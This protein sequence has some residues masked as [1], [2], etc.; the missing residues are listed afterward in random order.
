MTGTEILALFEDIID[1]SWDEDSAFLLMDSAKVAVEED[2]PWEFLKTEDSSKSRAVGDTF[3]STKAL[4]TNFGRDYKM[5]V[6][7]SLIEYFPVPFEER[8]R[9]RNL[10]RRYYIDMVN[11]VMGF[12][13]VAASA[14]TIYLQYLK[15][16]TTLTSANKAL[17]ILTWP[18]RFHPYLAFKMAE[19]YFA[20][21][22]A[23]D[24]TARMS[25]KHAQTAKMM[26]SAMVRWDTALKLRARGGSS[27]AGNVDISSLPDVVA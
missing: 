17:T 3:A 13:G 12:C 27:N 1:D 23:D 22:D 7:D 24:I 14:E 10:S 25:P 19:I 11:L 20:G 9:Y 8:R 15:T 21:I 2:R 16:T 4:P 5:Y 6:G 26:Y 18:T